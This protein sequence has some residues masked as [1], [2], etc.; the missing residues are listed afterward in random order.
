MPLALLWPPHHLLHTS[1]NS[2]TKNKEISLKCSSFRKKKWFGGLIERNY[3][4]DR[5]V[6]KD[7]DP[8]STSRNLLLCHCLTSPWAA[9]ITAPT[10]TAAFNTTKE[11]CLQKR[12]T[13]LGWSF[14]QQ[15]NRIGVFRL[16][17]QQ[18][19]SWEWDRSCTVPK[20][21]RSSILARIP[22]ENQQHL[23]AWLTRAWAAE[24]LH[25]HRL[26]AHCKSHHRAAPANLPILLYTLHQV[27]RFFFFL[28][29]THPHPTKLI[30]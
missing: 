15:Q 21:Q 11:R 27:K 12:E 18:G 9:W 10:S 20:A 22:E 13:W 14:L 24:R 8:N 1:I 19:G 16:T 7:S 6:I 2:H 28:L 23:S 5:V 26:Q 4:Q 25:P 17:S 29:N 3:L 30:N